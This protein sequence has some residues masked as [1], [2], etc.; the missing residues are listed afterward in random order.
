MG[1]V[2]AFTGGGTGGH[3]FPGLAVIEALRDYDIS[4]VCWIGS[5]KGVE[6]E[7][8]ESWSIP[9]YEVPAGK[10]RRYFSLHTIVDTFRVLAAF[11]VA[12][13]QLKK[14]SPAFAMTQI[15]TLD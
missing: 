11:F 8:A 7:I 13:Y 1:H 15:S 10:L 14:I 3:V 2:V 12:L 6:R 4:D 5:A 9:F